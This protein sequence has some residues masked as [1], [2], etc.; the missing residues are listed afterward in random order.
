VKDTK[1]MLASL[2]LEATGRKCD[3]CQGVIG[4]W[5]DKCYYDAKL[6]RAYCSTG[7]CTERINGTPPCVVCTAEVNPFEQGEPQMIPGVGRACRDCVATLGEK[8]AGK[9]MEP[10]PEDGL[11]PAEARVVLDGPYMVREVKPGWF[12]VGIGVGGPRTSTGSR[13]RAFQ[14]CAAFNRE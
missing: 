9:G 8:N 7:G 2:R 3:G 10:G 12:H 1:K 14:K 5:T 11:T 6:D 13:R 4:R